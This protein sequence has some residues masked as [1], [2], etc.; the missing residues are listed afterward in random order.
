MA[1]STIEQDIVLRGD[2]EAEQFLRILRDQSESDYKVQKIDIEKE[3]RDG[4]KSLKHKF[5]L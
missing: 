2:D 1:T 4:L 3:M 5:S